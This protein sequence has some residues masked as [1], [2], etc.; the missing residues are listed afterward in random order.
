MAPQSIHV[1]AA[2]PAG[3]PAAVRRDERDERQGARPLQVPSEQPYDLALRMI[4]VR[5]ETDG[6]PAHASTHRALGQDVLGEPAAVRT[7]LAAELDEDELALEAR[8][9]PGGGRRTMPRQGAAVVEVGMT[10]SVS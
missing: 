4:A 3:D 2:G 8:R 1:D 5:S 7:A 9:P 6:H 10:R